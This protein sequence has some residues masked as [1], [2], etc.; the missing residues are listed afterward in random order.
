M[1]RAVRRGAG[2]TKIQLGERCHPPQS[3]Q[4]IARWETS[5]PRKL[6]VRQLEIVGHALGVEPGELIGQA[7]GAG[8]DGPEAAYLPEPELTDTDLRIA[9]LLYP[10]G[11]ADVMIVYGRALEHAGLVPGD[12]VLVDTRAQPAPGDLVVVEVYD[13]S[14]AKR[15]TILRRYSPPMLM[16]ASPYA[17]YLAYPIVADNVD[18]RGVV[19]GT[20]RTSRTVEAE[21]PERAAP[22]RGAAA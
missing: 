12:R 16:P 17:R 5:D 15:E 8:A 4:N 22:R 14:A 11:R 13:G 6:T 21:E 7:I 20:Y 2:L 18:I 9:T 19:V 10:D 3:K 1:I